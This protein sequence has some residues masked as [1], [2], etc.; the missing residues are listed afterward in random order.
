MTRT[1]SGNKK[2]RTRS[3][4]MKIDFRFRCK[5][6]DSVPLQTKLK[7]P[8]SSR[9]HAAL[10]VVN[11]NKALWAR[12]NMRRV[13]FVHICAEKISQLFLVHV[14]R[15]SLYFWRFFQI[16]LSWSLVSWVYGQKKWRGKVCMTIQ[17]VRRGVKGVGNVVVIVNSFW[18][19]HNFMNIGD[20]ILIQ[21]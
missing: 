13:T 9:E 1:I 12:N 14:R 16:V 4:R 19:T 17:I 10:L 18:A 21:A 11:S 3:A 8:A 5:E 6:E 15:L 20:S 2:S 7:F